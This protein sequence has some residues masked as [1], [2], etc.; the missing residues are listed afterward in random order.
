MKLRTFKDMAVNFSHEIE[1]TTKSNLELQFYA[2]STEKIEVN[3]DMISKDIISEYY[4]M[5][6]LEGIDNLYYIVSEII[7]NNSSILIEY[8]K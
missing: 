7:N 1:H 3:P 2:Y 4:I 8:K 6:P 5:K